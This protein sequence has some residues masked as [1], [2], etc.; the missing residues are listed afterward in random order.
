MSAGL[1]PLCAAEEDRVVADCGSAEECDVDGWRRWEGRIEG[2][3][4]G[5]DVGWDIVQD[6]AL[7]WV[8]GLGERANRPR[9]VRKM[10]ML[11]LTIALRVSSCGVVVAGGRARCTNRDK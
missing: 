1:G 9:E 3:D 2:R 8:L 4:E 6:C 7:G 5:R 11:D 10:S